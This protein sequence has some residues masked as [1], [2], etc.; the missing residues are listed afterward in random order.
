MEDVLNV[1]S[2]LSQ[3]IAI[4]VGLITIWDRFHKKGLRRKPLSF[5]ILPLKL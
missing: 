3:I 2:I 5:F 4:L 1:V